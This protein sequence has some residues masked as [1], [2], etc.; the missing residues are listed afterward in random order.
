MDFGGLEQILKDGAS[1]LVLCSPHNPVG[2]VWTIDE[3][4]TLND[5]CMKYDT[6][7]L[8]DEIHAD[9]IMPGYKHSVMA[10]IC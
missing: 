8:A 1:M 5:L 3:L 7:I 6:L 2:R 4:Q 10:K 9:L